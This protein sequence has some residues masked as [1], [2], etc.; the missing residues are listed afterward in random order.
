VKTSGWRITLWI[1]LI[2]LPRLYNFSNFGVVDIIGDSDV[3]SYVEAGPVYS[4]HGGQLHLE[5]VTDASVSI[6][7]MG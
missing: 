5:E 4:L 2:E 7:F 6:C 1:R 3:E